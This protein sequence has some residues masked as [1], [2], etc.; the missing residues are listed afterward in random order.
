MAITYEK[1]HRLPASGLSTSKPVTASYTQTSGACLLVLMIAYAGTTL[2]T[3]GAPTYEKVSFTQ[4]D[5]ARCYLGGECTVETWYLLNS[6]ITGSNTVSIPNDGALSLMAIIADATTGSGYAGFDVASGRSA[7]GTN[8]YASVTTTK[9]NTLI[10]AHVASG[11]NAFAPTKRTGTN[12]MQEDLGTWG[13]AFQYYDKAAAGAQTLSWTESTSDDYGAIAAAFYELAGTTSSLS[14]YLKGGVEDTSKIT[15]L[16]VGGETASGTTSAYMNGSGL[17]VSNISACLYG[18][19]EDSSKNPAFLKGQDARHD[20]AEAYIVGVASIISSSLGY[21]EGAESVRAVP[22]IEW[23]QV[24][25]PASG[26][27]I[28]NSISAFITTGTMT[29]SNLQCYLTGQVAG[30]NQRWQILS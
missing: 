19:V 21:M 23:A 30:S 28:S 25:L 1:Y 29:S 5:S 3:G 2:R 27:R 4:A 7:L 17:P 9:G 24:L 11:D 6:G 22:E 12:I 13:V 18:S 14:S 15:V 20:Q 10:F 26:A 8:P 16:I